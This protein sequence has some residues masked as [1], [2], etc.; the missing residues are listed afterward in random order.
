MDPHPPVEVP[1]DPGEYIE[2]RRKGRELMGK[3]AEK[4]RQLL[5]SGKYGVRVEEPE[6]E[7][8]REK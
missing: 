8:G 2:R 7:E 1:K 5:A 4:G 3:L 6:T